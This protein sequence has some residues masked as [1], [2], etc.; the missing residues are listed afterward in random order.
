[1]WIMVMIVILELGLMLSY[2]LVG[3]QELFIRLFYF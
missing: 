3:I 2:I 1:M